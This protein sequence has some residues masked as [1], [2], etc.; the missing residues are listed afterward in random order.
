[1]RKIGQERKGKVIGC[2]RSLKLE[3]SEGGVRSRSNVFLLL[4]RSTGERDTSRSIGQGRGGKVTDHTRSPGS[5]SSGMEGAS[6]LELSALPQHLNHPRRAMSS[7]VAPP[8]S[9]TPLPPSQQH[10]GGGEQSPHKQ[11]ITALLTLEV[12]EGTGS[13]RRR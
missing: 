11:T 9:L 12:A 2:T 8:T 3:R 7:P 13:S 5:V 10:H 6:D 1:M 4:I